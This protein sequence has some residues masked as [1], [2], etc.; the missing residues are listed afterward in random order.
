VNFKIEPARHTDIPQLAALLNDLFEIELDFT[1][2]ASRQVRGLEI[3]ITEGTKSDRQIVAVARND[4]NQPVGMASGQIVISTAEGAPAV[5]IEDVVVHADHRR[6]GIG[7]QLLEFLQEWAKARGVTR[8]QLL[9]DRENAAANLFYTAIGW[10]STQ[11]MVRRR[12]VG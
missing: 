10:Q 7:R 3:L 6:R 8:L 9:A 11:L 12:L 2:D 5:W 1:A 4:Q